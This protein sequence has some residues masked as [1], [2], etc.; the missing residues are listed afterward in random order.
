MQAF[1][2]TDASINA[3]IR[4]NKT[5]ITFSDVQVKVSDID[6]DPGD[7]KN[8]NEAKVSVSGH[9]DVQDR[10][11]K[12][13]YAD[14]DIRSEGDVIPIDP[15][16]G[17][18]NPDLTYKI[19]VLKG[20][21]LESIPSLIKLAKKIEK[22][23]DYGLKLEGLG[24]DITLEQDAVITLGYRDS[25]LQFVEPV[26]IRFDGHLLTL[27][28]GAWLHTGSNLHEAKAEVLLSKSASD[29]ALGDS[30]QVLADKAKS[31]GLGGETVLRYADK[32]LTPV[33]KDGQIWIPF[34][35]TGDLNDP[36]VD[37]DIDYESLAEAI[38]LELLGELL[39][40]A[41]K[42]ASE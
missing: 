5:R 8:H 7:L 30:R 13:K 3:K 37:P 19:T 12:I 29:K 1:N 2:I 4:K 33:T 14:L 15:I 35:S 28:A 27:K 38:A 26:L 10:D 16:T 11:Y 24:I 18:F 23:N 41:Q 6:L 31:L 9:L 32:L 25:T 40:K 17:Y 22:F 36:K 42:D 21:K 20:S 34:S 39:N